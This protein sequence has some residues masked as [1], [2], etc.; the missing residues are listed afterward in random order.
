MAP[1]SSLSK[2]GGTDRWK[3]DATGYFRIDRT[4][5]GRWFF[6]DP[7]GCAFLTVGVAHADDSDLK[8][9]HNVEKVWKGR[10]G[11]SKERWIKEGLTKDLKEWGFNTIAWTQDY[12]GGGWRE[13]FDWAQ[14]V[15]V[16]QSTSQFTPRDFEVADMPYVYLLEVAETADW[17]GDPVFPDVWGDD[18]EDHC[19]YLARSVVVDH[20]DNPNLIG[21]SYVD[22]PS[23]APHV[24][25]ADF[26]QLLGLD[27]AARNEKLYDV[28]SKYYE[29]MHR[30]LREYDQNHLILGD[31]F[32]GDRPLPEPVLEALKP[33]VDVVG[34]QYFPGDTV[35]ARE[36]MKAHAASV[37]EITGKPLY[38]PDIGNWAP[39]ELNPHRVK[40]PTGR[41]AG[42]ESQAERARHYIETLDSVLHEPWCVGWH[43][44]AYFENL[45]R[46]WGMKDP[47][48]EPYEDLV[49]PVAEFNKTI[50]DRL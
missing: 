1:A 35:E 31:L 50:Y 34:V 33:Y 13:E 30:H 46:G 40:D 26:P 41:L 43:W 27:E 23:W 19:A 44:C 4:E 42:L 12:V 9:P 48:D 21:Y 7:D 29:T 10:Y 14:R 36:R 17:N 49:R 39:T 8:Y 16:Q 32:N 25:G 2:Y 20:A 6:V 38:I 47:W 28:A 22:A 45:A 18:F 15:T 37:V 11:A 5:E 24:S 3:F